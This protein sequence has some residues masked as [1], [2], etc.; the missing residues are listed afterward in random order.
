MAEQLGVVSPQLER[1]QQ[2][3]GEIHSAGA[4]ARLLVLGIEPEQST[5][6]R[7][8]PFLELPRTPALVLVLVDVV[9]HF[10]RHEARFVELERLDDLLDQAQL[11]LAVEN[12]EALRKPGL[13]PVQSQQTV[14]Q[15]VEGAQPQRASGTAEQCLDACAHLGRGLVGE[16]DGQDPM[17]RRTLGLDQPGDAM[18]QDA[19]LAAPG[20]GQHQGRPERGRDRGALGVVEGTEDGR[21]VHDGLR[22]IGR[23]FYPAPGVRRGRDGSHYQLFR[24]SR[25]ARN[26]SRG[27]GRG[28]SAG[29][30]SRRV[31]MRPGSLSRKKELKPSSWPKVSTG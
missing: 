23:K 30:R 1:A 20:A 3:L 9:L 14:R 10:A 16:G 27:V 29:T 2:Q 6:G 25:R 26:T 4:R 31:S 13:A 22:T 24:S 15:A 19:G 28:A 17:G 5:F 8:A 7:I 21:D 11:V 12:L 18:D